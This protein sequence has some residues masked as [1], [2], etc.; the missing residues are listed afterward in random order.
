MASAP[1]FLTLDK[2]GRTTLPE[3]VREALGVGAGD[4]V[5]L[6]RTDRGT[7]ELVPATLVPTDQ[8]W[9]HHPDMRAR[10]ARAEEDFAKGRAAKTSTPEEA[11]A[12]LDSLKKTPG[13]QH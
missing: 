1:T 11:Q 6:E 7:Y 8:L 12:L 2:K 4:F 5:L 3:E 13:S 9:F 10:I